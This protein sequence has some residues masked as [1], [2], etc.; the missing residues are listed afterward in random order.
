MPIPNDG[1]ITETNRQ[2]YEGAQGFQVINEN[3][4]GSATVI[5]TTSFTTTFNTDLIFGSD[6]PNNPNYALNNFKL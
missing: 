4:S 5:P 1:L 3:T 2:Y 6:D